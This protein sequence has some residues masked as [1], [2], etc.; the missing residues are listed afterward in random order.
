MIK[1]SKYLAVTLT[2]FLLVAS[3]CR[4]DDPITI[5]YDAVRRN[6]PMPGDARI[7]EALKSM[8]PEMDRA[9]SAP[10][11]KPIAMPEPAKPMALPSV[12]TVGRTINA[13]DAPMVPP[14]LLIRPAK[15][16]VLDPSVL[17]KAYETAGK[18][19]P[20][21]GDSEFLVFVSF[22]IPS[23]ELKKLIESADDARAIVVFRG[24][25]D[26][27]DTSLRKFT[28]RIQSLK[29]KRA[30]E[31]QIS[32]PAFTKYRVEQVPAFVL[33]KVAESAAEQNGCAPAGSYA[34]VD[35]LIAPEYALNIMKSRARADIAAT[36]ERYLD[37][38]KARRK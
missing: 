18:P 38:M 21:K 22:S 25:I 37:A 19:A 9:L 20:A 31:I 14:H 3:P 8:K 34:S 2:G 24:P 16:G 7:N 30:G 5:D 32:P 36:A 33:A 1:R 23:V 6:H 13:P 10:P 4:A 35:G 26:E 17:A 11:V 29:L 27:A 28:A 12:G 15:G